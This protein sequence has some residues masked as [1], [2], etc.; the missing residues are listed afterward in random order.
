MRFAKISFAIAGWWGIAQITPLFFL[1]NEVGRRSPPFVTHP[2]FYF[3]FL[4][5]TLAWQIAFLGISRN[6]ARYRLLMVP[7]VIEK[8]GFA[9]TYLLLYLHHTLSARDASWATIDFL[10]GV[11]FVISYLRCKSTEAVIAK[12]A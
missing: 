7:A 6:P 12:D 10:L 9:L 1:L 11:A 2:E 4:V 3:G 8:F 5:V